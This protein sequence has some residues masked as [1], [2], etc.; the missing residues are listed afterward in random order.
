MPEFDAPTPGAFCWVELATSDQTAA[1]AFYFNIFGWDSDDIPLG[2]DETYTMFQIDGKNV[3]A[4]FRITPQMNALGVPPA[5]GLYI[6][7]EDADASAKKAVKHGGKILN[8]PFDV[9]DSGRMAVI[10]DPTGAVFSIW[11]AKEHPGME[12]AGEEDTFCWA[13]LITDDVDS[14]KTFLLGI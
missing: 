14:A 3:G 2:P 9:M 10:Q 5:W 7:V 1:K 4:A 13:D 11:Q 12:L 8:G 6:A